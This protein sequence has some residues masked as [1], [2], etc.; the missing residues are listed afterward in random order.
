MWCRFITQNDKLRTIWKQKEIKYKPEQMW[1]R[2][3][4]NIGL[5]QVLWPYEEG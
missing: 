1:G 2:L 3:V 4:L 5:V